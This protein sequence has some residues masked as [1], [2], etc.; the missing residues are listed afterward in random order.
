MKKIVSVS[1][2]CVMVAVTV[3][4]CAYQNKQQRGTA[5]GAGVGAAAG[6]IV[7]QAAGKS[8]EATLWGAAIGALVGGIAGNQIGAYMDRQEVALRNALAASEAASIQR[9]QDVLTATFKSDV[10]FKFDSADLLPGG[11]DEVSR[12]AGV[13]N[14]Y[15]RTKIRVEGHT[16]SAG[17]EAYNQ[18]LSERR[19]RSVAAALVQQGVQPV[20]IKTIGFGESRP[21]SSDP[22]A[23][24]RVRIVI[25]PVQQG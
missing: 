7:G 16:D 23:N 4:G 5:V 13:L 10:F 19:A 22:A 17:T 18:D 9:E 21:V 14:S 11:I 8:T 3:S 25:E 15:P 24:R 12:V 2:V 1:V 20:R 6:A